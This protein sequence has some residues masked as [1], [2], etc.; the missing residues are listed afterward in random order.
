ML[1][2]LDL[3]CGRKILTPQ[4]FNLDSSHVVLRKLYTIY[5]LWISRKDKSHP[6]CLSFLS[7]GMEY[8]I[9]FAQ[10]HETFRRP[11]IQALA[12]LHN[13]QLEIIFYSEIV[14]LFFSS[15]LDMATSCRWYCLTLPRHN[16]N[17]KNTINGTN[18]TSPHTASS[19]FQTK[20]PLEHWYLDVS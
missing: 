7:K 13:I 9:R 19:G 17:D 10:T 8:L 20:K 11:E 14:S 5:P 12:S 16:Q 4:H 1:V 2:V 15:S 3:F 18:T 6:F